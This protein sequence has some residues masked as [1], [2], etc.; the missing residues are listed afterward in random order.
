MSKNQ[1]SAVTTASAQVKKVENNKNEKTV[2][3]V[4]INT[5]KKEAEAAVKE[6]TAHKPL[7]LDELTE[8]AEKLNLLRIKLEDIKEKRK[9]LQAFQISHDEKNA[10]LTIVDATGQRITTSSPTSIGQVIN[11]WGSEL[12]AHLSNVETSMRAILEAF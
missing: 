1:A 7:T 2:I 3:P 8:R 9:Q 6:N 11:I 4:V 10:Q 12:D 5:Q